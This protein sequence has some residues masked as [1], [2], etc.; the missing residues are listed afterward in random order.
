MQVYVF[1]SYGHDHYAERTQ[2]LYEQLGKCEDDLVIWWD[3]KLK[4]SDDWVVEIENRLNDLIN[5]RPES[6]FI[7]VVTPYSSNTDRDNFCIKEIA[8]A[9]GGR[10]R[11]IPVKIVEAPMPLLLSNIQWLDLTNIKI[12]PENPEFIHRIKELRTIIKECRDLPYDG[13]QEVLKSRLEPCDFTLDLEKH[14]ANY[15]E[16]PWLLKDVNQWITQSTDHILLLLGGPGTGKTAFSIWMGYSKLSQYIAAWHLCQFNNMRTCLLANAVKSIAYYLA[17]RIP[18]YYN[19]LDIASVDRLLNESNLDAGT[20][21]KELILDKLHQIQYDGDQLVILIDALDESSRDGRNELAEMLSYYVNQFPKW[22]KIIITSRNDPSVTT[23]LEDCS[24]VINLDDNTSIQHS[25]SDIRSYV[26][27][28][29]GDDEPIADIVSSESGNN[30]LYAQLLCNSIKDNPNFAVG[31]L[32]KGINSYYND[33]MNRYFKNNKFDFEEHALPLLNLLLTSYEPLE[34]KTIYDRL[35]K[36]NDWCKR[37]SVFN[38][39]LKCFGPLLKEEADCLCPFHKSLSDWFLDN[40][41]NKR[42]SVFKTDGLEEMVNWGFEIMEED[43]PQIDNTM[44]IHFYR[45]LP[46]YIIEY[47]KKDLFL[48]LYTDIDFWKRRQQ[49]LGV[50]SVLSLMISEIALCSSDLKERLFFDD[51]FFKVL[52]FFN[53]DLFN[54]GRY[55]SLAQLGY[56]IKMASG[57]DDQHRLFAIRYFYINEFLHEIDAHVSMFEE[58]YEDH[59]IEAMLMNE[60]GQ[61]YRKFGQLERSAYYYRKALHGFREF[62]GTQDETIYSMLN[63]SRILM[64]QRKETEARQL[65]HEAIELFESG[66]WHHS[67]QGT[68]FEFSAQQLER[69]VRYVALETECFSLST[70][71]NVC[72][73]SLRWADDTYAVP[74]KRD[75]YY[76]NHLISKMFF[77]LKIGELDGFPEL[78]EESQKSLS[79]KYDGIRLSCVMSIYYLIKG[80][81]VKAKQIVDER[82]NYLIT[83]PI[84]LIQRTEF[85][86]IQDHLSDSEHLESVSEELLPWYHHF[87][88]LISRIVT[89]RN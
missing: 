9:L 14:L 82:M 86:A 23:Y 67:I 80:D 13:K 27:H 16:R 17:V 43:Q 84:H 72:H 76:I 44:T 22:L 12:D 36:T 89:K 46:H 24:T 63:L 28:M 81:I 38:S 50:N 18:S 39:L 51:T 11:V 73:E 42:F 53:I 59:A 25:S 85:I 30:F 54:T 35:H 45:Y 19:S 52:D 32:P 41:N 87:K 66:T 61:T 10:V 79:S 48:S 40:K 77:K 70:D 88:M 3:K 69:G 26:K 57:M 75:R 6:C 37:Y 55:K 21:F 29:I 2:I 20:L 78:V 5:N 60:L 1:I 34:T 83:L 62:G 65:L 33:Y 7:Y 4:A 58:P 68:D 64:M 71:E 56:K 49:V 31:C 8:K 74:S 15:Q 47:D